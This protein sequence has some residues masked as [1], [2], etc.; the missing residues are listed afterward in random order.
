VSATA[1]ARRYCHFVEGTELHTGVDSIDRRSPA[2]G[3]LVAQFA[4]GSPADMAA[5][6]ASA[7][8]AFDTGGWPHLSGT[9]RAE[10]LLELA[11]RIAADSDRLARIEVEEAGKPL[12]LAQDELSGVVSLTRLAAGLGQQL[13]G[14]VHTN[15][16]PAHTGMV[17]R[18]PIGVVG[19]IV[20]WN[21]A[22][23]IFAQKVPFALAAGCTVVVKPSEFTSGT[24]LEMARLAH[25][26][27]VP[28]GVLN[29]VTGYGPEV[30][31]VLLDSPDVDMISFTGSTATGLRVLDAQKSNFKR[32]SLEL[33]GKSANIVLADADLE[34]ALDGTLKG[35]FFNSGQACCA[36]TRLLIQDTIADAFLERL[37]ARATAL[38]TGD[39]FDLTTDLGSLIHEHHTDQ[40]M[41]HI[42][43]GIEAGARLLTG[44]TRRGACAV[45][46]TIFDNVAPEMALFQEE[47]FGP[48]LSVTR[49][50][51]AEHAV[52]LA[53]DTQYGLAA[54]L[55]T[56]DLDTALL[57][58]RRLRSGTVWV[59][60]TIDSPV[61]LPFG[62][63][64]AS[65]YGREMGAAG[66]DEFTELKAVSIRH[67]PHT[68]FFSA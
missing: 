15:V 34:A 67:G 22:S 24:A 2:S 7:R 14:D 36:G 43:R 63:Y 8:R 30:G 33:G 19:A 55:W 62:G 3:D 54:S 52:Q 48:V 21:W 31:Q 61:Q 49:V 68:P 5:A 38:R 51:D 4:A 20:P 59:N 12:R 6:I 16:G 66:L 46:P 39:L 44:G 25:E 45:D 58:S 47:I 13:H 57:M 65:G 35:V 9:D 37:V 11:E 28:S 32:V 50:H 17:M 42:E 10:I 27:G 40:V 1:Q 23:G 56:K 64:K 41:G 26:A 53:N 60:T 18:E 29:V